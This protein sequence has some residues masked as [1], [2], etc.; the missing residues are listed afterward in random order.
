MMSPLIA[1]ASSGMHQ[2][3]HYIVCPFAG[4]GSGSFRAWRN[5]NLSKESVSIML[6]PGRETRID[7]ATLES[8]ESLAEEMVQALLASRIPIENTIIVGHSMGAQVAYEASR[9]LL[10]QGHSPR[11]L[12][13]SGCQAPHI[14]GRRLLGECDDTT[15][16]TNLIEMGGCDISLADNPQWWPI[17]LPA[18]RA[19]FTATEQYLF[20]SP[21]HRD[22]RLFVPTLLVSGDKDQEAYYSEVEEW[23][24]WCNNVIEHLVVKGGHFYVTEHPEMMLDCL[25]ALSIEVAE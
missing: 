3:T 12:I 14:K 8:I 15:F 24:L 11:G 7:D 10:L 21:P 23:K 9:K 13:I 17:F 19:D 18:L 25:R 22:A 5:L 2:D 1:I 6:Y 4:G 16:I 20:S